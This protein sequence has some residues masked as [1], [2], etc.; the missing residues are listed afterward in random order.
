MCV[1]MWLC[2]MSADAFSL[3]AGVAVTYEVPGVVLVTEKQMLL[4]VDPFPQH[5]SYEY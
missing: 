1:C 2:D 5:Y 3:G 4:S